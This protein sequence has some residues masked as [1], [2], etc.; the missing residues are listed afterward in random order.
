M[1]QQARVTTVASRSADQ[2]GAPERHLRSR[3]M[4][5]MPHRSTGLLLLLCV[6]TLSMVSCSGGGDGNASGDPSATTTARDSSAGGPTTTDP[7]G[8]GTTE[9]VEV[10]DRIRVEVLSSQPDRVSGDEARIRIT[11]RSGEGVEGIRVTVDGRDVTASLSP[12]TGD[13]AGT[14]EG[15]VDGLHEG[16]NSL[17]ASSG[18]ETSTLRL[19]AWPRQ[20]PMI[21][22]P[23]TP[24]FA[25]ATE[26]FGL[27]PGTDGTCA[28]PSRVTWKAVTADSKV[29]DVTN[30]GGHAPEGTVNA[31]IDGESVPALVRVE[32][33][34]LNRSTYELAIL[35]RAPGRPDAE[36]DPAWNGRLVVR[37]DDGC[38]TGREGGRDD[39]VA[40]QQQRGVRCTFQDLNAIAFGVDPSTGFAHRPVDNTGLQY[41]LDALNHGTIGVD[42]FLDLNEHIGGLD[43]DGRPRSTRSEV[44]PAAL[45]GM[46]ENG[47]I[48]EGVGD[49]RKVPLV[50]IVASPTEGRLGDLHQALATRD[51]LTRG[52]SPELAPGHQ[53]W[54]V[55]ASEQTEGRREASNRAIGVIDTWLTAMREVGADPQS[56]LTERP[57]SAVS[58]CG[59]G[60]DQIGVD[61]F[62]NP[63]GSCLGADRP[64]GDPR[65]VAGGPAT[66]DVVKCQLKPID[67]MDYEVSFSSAQWDRLTS[68]FPDGVCDWTSA[69]AG[70]TLPT[71]PDRSFAD[72][73]VP[74]DL[75]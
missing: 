57:D 59:A 28:A 3:T 63:A 70:Q 17:T 43:P 19:R 26:A 75:A 48:A 50:D 2:V 64:L 8:T 32:R 54:V 23:Q 11:P 44:D 72:A 10:A 29:V 4:V 62:D 38:G 39:R 61:V 27:G 60:S 5:A 14:V 53:I 66:G 12:G 69:G 55:P 65:I 36:L 45:Q 30:P 37:F 25:C 24:L 47:R 52:G 74:A 7:P 71:M 46:Y 13:R 6:L 56:L 22:G 1:R 15:V 58:R 67:S 51:R 16:T 73:E 33:G 41:G 68:I 40:L 9:E 34:V 31:K 20:G 42:E 21:S 49:M 18:T 35:D